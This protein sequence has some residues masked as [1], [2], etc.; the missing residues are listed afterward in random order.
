MGETAWSI[1]VIIPFIS[2]LFLQNC[3][4]EEL[5]IVMESVMEVLEMPWRTSR[6]GNFLWFSIFALVPKIK[7]ISKEQFFG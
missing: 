5:L 6:N 2:S 3:Y 4:E 7:K 1:D